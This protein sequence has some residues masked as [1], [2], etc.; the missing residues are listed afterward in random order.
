MSH[1]EGAIMSNKDLRVIKTEQALRNALLELGN[2]KDFDEITI[3][4]VCTK[5]MVRR[6]TFYR[7]YED[8]F[9]FYKSTIIYLLNSYN[10]KNNKNYNLDHPEAFYAAMINDVILFLEQ[11]KNLAKSVIHSNIYGVVSTIIYQQLYSI[12]ETHLSREKNNGFNFNQ[13]IN[14]LAEFST[15]GIMRIIFNWLQSGANDAQ[16]LSRSI[17]NMLNQFWERMRTQKNI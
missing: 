17:E 15:G 8:K 2:I 12:I 9:H 4:E 7:H 11:N 16:N 5:A 14:L 10:E 13:D 1:K 6:S 3:N